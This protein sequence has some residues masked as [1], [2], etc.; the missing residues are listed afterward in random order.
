MPLS[1]L[2]DRLSTARPLVAS[3][4]N[5]PAP[6]VAIERTRKAPG[7]PCWPATRLIVALVNVASTAPLVAL[8]P[9]PFA[10][11]RPPVALAPKIVSP[12]RVSCELVTAIL[13]SEPSALPPMPLRSLA[14]PPWMIGLTTRRP[15]ARFVWLMVTLKFG[16]CALPPR[17]TPLPPRVTKSPPIPA[18]PDAS[19]V[20]LM[21]AEL[22]TISSEPVNPVKGLTLNTLP[23]CWPLPPCD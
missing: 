16:P 17:T 4:M 11:P 22:S 5:P 18:T 10:P 12:G 23:P 8:P 1:V 14:S 2:L 15:P 21:V 9:L 20:K 3:P 13:T 7:A 6:P 19:G